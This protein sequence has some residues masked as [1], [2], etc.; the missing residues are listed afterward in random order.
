M[1]WLLILLIIILLG[2]KEVL[3]TNIDERLFLLVDD[4]GNEIVSDELIAI[5][6]RMG[7]IK[8]IGNYLARGVCG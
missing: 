1:L 3:M 4:K 2:E 8:E 6:D 7:L 5:S